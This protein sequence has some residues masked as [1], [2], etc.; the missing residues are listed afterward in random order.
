MRV[1]STI[2]LLLASC[3]SNRYCAGAGPAG[4]T[5]D[6]TA[7]ARSVARPA[8]FSSVLDYG[9]KCDG[10]SDDREAFR[11]AVAAAQELGGTVTVPAATCAIAAPV[12]FGSRPFRITGAGIEGSKIKALARMP[13]MFRWNG[14]GKYNYRTEFSQLRLDGNGLAERAVLASRV[15]HLLIFRT[16]ITGTTVAALDLAYGWDNDISES[17][18]AWNSGIGILINNGIVDGIQGNNAIRIVNTKIVSNATGIY[19]SPSRHVQITGCTLDSNSRTAIFIPRGAEGTIIRDNYFEAN[20]QEGIAFRT[21]ATVVRADIVVN[22]SAQNDSEM[23]FASPARGLVVEGNYAFATFSKQFAYLIAAAGAR[24][25]GNTAFRGRSPSLIGLLDDTRYT[26][27]G[28]LHFSGNQDF[29]ELVTIFPSASRGVDLTEASGSTLPTVNYFSLSGAPIS[30]AGPGDTGAVHGGNAS[31]R[32]GVPVDQIA[33]VHSLGAWRSTLR[34]EDVPDLAGAT[35]TVSA[36]CSSASKAARCSIWTSLGAEATSALLEEDR[37][38]R[39]S[40]TLALPAAGSVTFEVRRQGGPADG[41]LQIARPL[42]THTGVPGS[43]T[44]GR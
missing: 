35:V 30:P 12:E 3:S 22:G 13:A 11:L 10:V 21:P 7:S 6:S 8:G 16:L 9:A 26:S 32:R 4:P 36:L 29:S 41:S 33:S 20:A 24:L 19:V 42:L 1:L 14:E 37:W 2:A 39:V 18:I 44:W 34:I 25:V 38:Q 31:L 17:H 27:I 5:L 15:A 40:L 43:L 28:G 23:G